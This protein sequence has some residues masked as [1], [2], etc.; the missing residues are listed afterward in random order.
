WTQWQLPSIYRQLNANLLFSPLP[1]API[2]SHCR[3]VVMVHDLIPLRFPSFT[4][5]L[6]HYFRYYVP[7]VL[8]QAKHIICNSQATAKDITEYYQIPADKITS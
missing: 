1:E 2:N 8:Q 3:F 6:T 5:P 7:Q 4:S